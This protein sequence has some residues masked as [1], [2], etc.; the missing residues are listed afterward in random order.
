MEYA[1]DVC[2]T[3][4]SRRD[5]NRSLRRRET[6]AKAYE[7]DDLARRVFL[8]AMAGITVQIAIIVLLIY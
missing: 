4:E 1:F 3:H 6:M 7:P 8:L 2:R 5:C